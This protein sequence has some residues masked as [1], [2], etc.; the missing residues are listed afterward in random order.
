M[1]LQSE[2]EAIGK[3]DFDIYPKELA[4]GFYADDQSV[5]Q[6]GKAVVNREEYIIDKQGQKRWLNTSKLPLR[7]AEGQTIGL[8]GVGRDITERKKADEALRESEE[9]FRIIAEQTGRLV[10]DYRFETGI[11]K[12]AGAI[13]DVTGYTP[14]EHRNSTIF[15]WRNNIHPEDRER[16]VSLIDEA[17]KTIGHYLIEYRYR[18]RDGEYIHIE[19]QG[20]S[21]KNE[22]GKVERVLGAIENITE[23]KRTVLERERLIK[24]L[25]DAVADIKV[26]SGLVPICSNCKKIRDDKGYWT[27]LEGYIQAHSQAKFSHGVCPDCMVKLYPNYIP[28]KKE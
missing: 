6:T 19:D 4:D 9:R 18:R 1:G 20:V 24:E 25:Q 5:I 27:Q 16:A 7:D 23:R 15:D 2:A 22:S 8:V 21:L 10:Y 26:L 13:Q 17:N 3:D 28:K 11:I 14:N 12:W